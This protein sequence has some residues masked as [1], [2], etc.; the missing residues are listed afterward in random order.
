[1]K[2]HVQC[3]KNYTRTCSI[4]ASK[5]NNVK[6]VDGIDLSPVKRRLRSAGEGKFDFQTACLFCGTDVAKE[7]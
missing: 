4:R 2:V 5:K 6:S 1:M 7:R 3:R